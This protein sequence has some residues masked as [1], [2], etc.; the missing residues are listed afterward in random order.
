MPTNQHFLASSII[1]TDVAEA[2]HV[3]KKIPSAHEPYEVYDRHIQKIH[4]T[5]Q[6]LQGQLTTLYTQKEALKQALQF[7]QS[8]LKAT[9]KQENAET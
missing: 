3:S 4:D 5:A 1:S 7:K 2:H 6:N 8:L 9:E